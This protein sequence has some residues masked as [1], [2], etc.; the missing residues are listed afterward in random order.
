MAGTP[1]ILTDWYRH[2]AA[3]TPAAPAY[4]S[5]VDGRWQPID[6]ASFVRE[7]DRFAARLS[8]LGLG[9]GERVGIMAPTGLDWELMQVAALA[10]GAAVVGLDAHDQPARL[11]D[12]VAVA[13]LTV[14]VVGDARGYAR[15]PSAATARLRFVLCLGD[16]AAP[17]D[18]RSRWIARAAFDRLEGTPPASAPTPDMLATIVFTSGSTG[19]PKG[20]AYTH[21]QVCL[22]VAGILEAFPDIGASDRLVCWLPLSNLFQRMI[23][24]CAAGRGAQTYFV[25]DPR[26]II[27]LLPSIRPQVFIAVP[28]FFEKLNEG[29]EQQL[30]ARPAWAR[31]LVAWSLRA[32]DAV[33]HARRAGRAP[34]AFDALRGALAERLVLRRLRGVLGGEVRFM[35]SGS[36]P[37]PRWLLE[38][39]HAMGLLVLEAYGLSENVVPI[40]VNRVDDYAFGSVGRIVA[41]NEV[42]LADDGEVLVRGAGVFTGYL[43]ASEVESPLSAE[44]FL[45]TGDLGEFDEAGRL[46]LTGRKSEIF[47]TSTGRKIAPAAVEARLKQIAGLDHAVVFG[48]GR[49]RIVALVTPAPEAIDGLREDAAWREWT[50]AIAARIAEITAEDNDYLRPAGVLVHRAPFTIDG[51]ELTSN[52]KLRRKQ[53]EERHRVA[54]DALFAR[55]ER[56]GS[57]VE[58]AAPDTLMS[59]C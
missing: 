25:A 33:A 49:K 46:R 48:A 11:A 17:E 52:L 47:K 36:A 6:W 2:R 57:F 1:A 15:L 50:R 27:A 35:V 41:G 3:E 7:A 22:A 5:L 12:I 40:A 28:R 13:E 16:D 19:A 39:F 55:L 34:G 45:H 54:L 21:A 56:G 20:I 9:A 26:S 24:F 10:C 38:R 8:A 31:A 59:N 32:G 37:F 43:G 14:L 29:I 42:R 18:C 53:I 30:A 51:G 58:A 23:D 4:H 44:G